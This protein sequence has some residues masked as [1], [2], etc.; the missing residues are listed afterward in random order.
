MPRRRLVEGRRAALRGRGRPDKVRT[1]RGSARPL[2]ARHPARRRGAYLALL[3]LVLQLLVPSLH[4]SRLVAAGEPSDAAGFVREGGSFAA[5]AAHAA[6][7][8]PVCA[9]AAQRGHGLA[10]DVAARPIARTAEARLAPADPA[11]APRAPHRSPG[12]PRAPPV[13][14]SLANA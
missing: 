5:E 11:R 13:A 3:A 1:M 8:C 7:G 6:H 9:A 4:A 10:P 2:P 12:S 14:P